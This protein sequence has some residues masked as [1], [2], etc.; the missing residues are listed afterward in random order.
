[1]D[2]AADLRGAVLAMTEPAYRDDAGVLLAAYRDRLILIASRGR[3]KADPDVTRAAMDLATRRAARMG[4]QEG[5]KNGVAEG[6]R[7]AEAERPAPEPPATFEVIRDAAG[8]PVEILERRGE[9]LI[10]KT[11]SHDDQGRVISIREVAGTV[12]A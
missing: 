4:L 6:R 9:R 1:M 11:V 10:R 7:L 2:E 5:F 3:P 8:R 12:R